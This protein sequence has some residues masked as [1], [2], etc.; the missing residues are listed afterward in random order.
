MMVLAC[1]ALATG[2][3]NQS[4]RC[5]NLSREDLAR[6]VSDVELAPNFSVQSHNVLSLMA[7]WRGTSLQDRQKAGAYE[8]RMLA[9]LLRIPSARIAVSQL[10]FDVRDHIGAA[11]P[12][13]DAALRDQRRRD[14]E[15]AAKYGKSV[16][17]GYAGSY[18]DLNCIHILIR[19][20]RID[21]RV[22]NDI[23][24]ADPELHPPEN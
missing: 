23:A 17:V 22:C 16:N 18:K 6:A 11:R 13:V 3:I 21:H 10:L 8:V 15:W 24:L 2:T 14:A 19:T 12:D 20:G 7:Y 9:R 4:D 5:P 1:L